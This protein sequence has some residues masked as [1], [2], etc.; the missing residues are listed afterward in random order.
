LSSEGAAGFLFGGHLYYDPRKIKALM[1][2]QLGPDI[3]PPPMPQ[4]MQMAPAQFNQQP[5]PLG[6]LA[7]MGTQRAF[8]LL[9]K[10]QQLP[11]SKL[12]TAGPSALFKFLKLS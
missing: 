3:E 2:Q 9:L 4:M 12:A 11:V 5:A 8:D 6:D 7:A 10:K 1:G